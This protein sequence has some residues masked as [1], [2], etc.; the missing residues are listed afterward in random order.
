MSFMMVPLFAP[1]LLPHP[2][3]ETRMQFLN[4]PVEAIGV[5]E[6]PPRQHH[7]SGEHHDDHENF[8]HL[9]LHPRQG[10]F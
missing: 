10:A 9:S 2:L 1:L 8:K 7:R 5:A 4:A 3:I 6:S